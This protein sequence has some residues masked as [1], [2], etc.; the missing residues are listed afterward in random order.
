VQGA[1]LLVGELGAS[2][3]GLVDVRGVDEIRGFGRGIGPAD[4]K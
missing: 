4:P 3:G 1:P 2:H